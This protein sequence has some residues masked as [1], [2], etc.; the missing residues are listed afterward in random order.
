MERFFVQTFKT[1]RRG[2][3]VAFETVEVATE[4]RAMRVAEHLAARSGGAVA[5]R[6]GEWETQILGRFG[7]TPPDVD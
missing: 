1:T 6:A 7:K 5:C 4:C 2:R 3:V